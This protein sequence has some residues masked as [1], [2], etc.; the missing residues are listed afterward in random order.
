MT[1]MLGHLRRARRN[2]QT[3]GQ[4]RGRNPENRELEMPGAQELTRED[5]RN[6]DAI[7]TRRVGSEV[8]NSAADEDL[9]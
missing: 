3:A 8:R 9:G 6:V 2:E 4:K 5:A 7:E 1:D